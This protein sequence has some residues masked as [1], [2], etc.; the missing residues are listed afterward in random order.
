MGGI[1]AFFGIMVV[2]M[3]GMWIL[4][5]VFDGVLRAV[6]RLIAAP[7][8]AACKARENATL[9]A[10]TNGIYFDTVTSVVDLR[11]ALSQHFGEDDFHPANRVVV[12]TDEPGRFVVGIAWHEQTEFEFEGGTS[13]HGS[14]L[15]VVVAEVTY[16][17]NDD[18]TTGKM[19]LTRFP[20]DAGWAENSILEN[21]FPWIFGAIHELDPAAQLNK[22]TPRHV[23]T[24]HEHH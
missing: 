16:R 17:A 4:E 9:D 14:G 19:R 15:P 12:D 13:A 10:Y 5:S 21:V 18:R 11:E 23:T 2:I 22:H 24:R 3:F 20:H 1:A 7:F 6:S 8:K